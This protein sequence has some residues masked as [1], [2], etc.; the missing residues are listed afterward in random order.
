LYDGRSDYFDYY[1]GISLR[2]NKA[3]DQHRVKMVVLNLRRKTMVSGVHIVPRPS[4]WAVIREGA[5][6]DSSHHETQAEAI[7]QG[8][9]T[10]R[11]EGA[12]LYIHGTDGKI[13]ER[14]SYGNDPFPPKG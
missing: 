1:T 7:T 11:R 4:G 5:A 6:R 2:K 10:A 13:R 9:E 8:T 14:N 3:F 12:E